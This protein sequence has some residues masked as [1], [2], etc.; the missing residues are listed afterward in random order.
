M[1]TP[2]PVAD[3]DDPRLAP[4][5]AIRERD[6]VGRGNRFVVEGEVVLRLMLARGRFGLESVLLSRRRVAGSP[7]LVAA[8]PDGVPLYVADDA[9]IEAIAA[10]PSIAACSPSASGANRRR[11]R[12]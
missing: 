1:A 5:Q 4:Y 6:L 12:R 2:L 8:I 11:P 7:D 3:P 10:S 9:L